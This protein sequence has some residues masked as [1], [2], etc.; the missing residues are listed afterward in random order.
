MRNLSIFIF[1]TT[2]LACPPAIAGPDHEHGHEHK[3][4]SKPVSSA[5]AIENATTK[6]Q[7]LVKTGKIDSTWSGIKANKAEQKTYEKGPE[8]VVT[9][10]NKKLSDKS[11]QTLYLFFTLSGHYIAANYTGN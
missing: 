11:K 1:I 10:N 8:W 5:V 4:A 6:V 7:Q 2:L 9:F 3:H